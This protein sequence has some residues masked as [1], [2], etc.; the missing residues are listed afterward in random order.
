MVMLRKVL[1]GMVYGL[2]VLGIYL[3]V[4]EPRILFY[5]Y[6][7]ILVIS[8]SMSWLGSNVKDKYLFGPAMIY[9]GYQVI[10]G[11]FSLANGMTVIQNTL[12]L[13]LFI[14]ASWFFYQLRKTE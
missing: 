7:I 10:S 11:N 2:I 9:A 6:M 5:L 13:V 1:L 8:M 12:L 3:S 4:I 14:F